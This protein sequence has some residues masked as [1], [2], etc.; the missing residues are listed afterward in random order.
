MINHSRVL[1]TG[2][3]GFVAQHVVKQ[4]RRGRPQDLFVAHS[5]AYNLVDGA[6]VRRL[7]WDARPDV[8]IHLA[9]K[10]G[11]IAANREQPATF[12][13]ENLTRNTR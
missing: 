12:F 6:D 3:T 4:I 9:A 10:V 2:G 13:Y 7:L 1:V 11:G 8:V 5:H